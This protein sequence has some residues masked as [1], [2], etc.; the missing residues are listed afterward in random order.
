MTR[1]DGY[2]AASRGTR[3]LQAW[4]AIPVENFA[5]TTGMPTNAV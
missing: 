4:F 5:T 2:A 3:S 1:V